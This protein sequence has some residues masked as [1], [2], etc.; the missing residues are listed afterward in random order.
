MLYI[1]TTARPYGG[2]P[3]QLIIFLFQLVVFARVASPFVCMSV[4]PLG[5]TD[6]TEDIF[7]DVFGRSDSFNTIITVLNFL[8][9]LVVLLFSIWPTN[10]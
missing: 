5:Y 4:Y 2:I 10:N 3:C 1:P 9:N 8:I 7:A 6:A